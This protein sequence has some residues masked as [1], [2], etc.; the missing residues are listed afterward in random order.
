MQ[1]YLSHLKLFLF[2]MLRG[3][4][5][6]GC[7]KETKSSRVKESFECGGKSS[8]QWRALKQKEKNTSMVWVQSR[9][10]RFESLS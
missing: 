5:K 8:G 6:V 10:V 4:L 9:A 2:D 1:K 7:Q 3:L